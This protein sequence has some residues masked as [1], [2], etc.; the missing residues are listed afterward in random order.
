ML[1]PRP[2]YPGPRP[3]YIDTMV[4]RLK[5]GL[6]NHLRDNL[7]P[8]NTKALIPIVSVVDSLPETL[9]DYKP[10]DILIHRGDGSIYRVIAGEGGIVKHLERITNPI[11]GVAWGDIVDKPTEFPPSEHG[12]RAA[13]IGGLGGPDVI[14]KV[15]DY[16]YHAV[17]SEFNRDAAA[18][19]ADSIRTMSGACS[20][21]RDGKLVGRNFDWGFD[22]SPSFVVQ[23]PAVGGRRASVSMCRAPKNLDVSD[24]ND[25]LL[26]VVPFLALDGVNDAGVFCEVNVV[27]LS[28]R[29]SG[30]SGNRLCAV[31]AVREALDRF[32]DAA[33]AAAMIA[34][35]CWIPNIG[36][37]LHFMVCDPKE[38]WIVEDGVATKV[39]GKAV[40]TNFR[41]N[42]GEFLT[43]G[44]PDIEKV[45][46]FDPLGTGLERYG[47]LLNGDT[48]DLA[49]LDSLMLDA[50]FTAAYDRDAQPRRYTEF[51]GCYLESLGREVTLA[52]GLAF[53]A[54]YADIAATSWESGT[55]ESHRGETGP[56]G[57]P[58]W[59]QSVHSSIYDLEARTLSVAIQELAGRR[60]FGIVAE[61]P[62]RSVDGK[63]PDASGNVRVD[64]K[65]FA[66]KTIALDTDNDLYE[67]VQ[68][69]IESLGGTVR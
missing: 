5:D 63:R 26:A 19:Y 14:E 67:A 20:V 37:D 29:T 40:M 41:V 52:D 16:L 32:T 42:A 4:R 43:D 61:S 47:L 51:A 10:T 57:S 13:D 2:L 56:D 3:P 38:T 36:Y 25:P 6:E 33:S 30:W 50:R 64:V 66:G 59:W 8:H 11:S 1:K 27:P 54:E 65:P 39:T 60:S 23:A 34:S 55:K 31:F 12:H 17:W 9:D 24:P 49:H 22:S 53:L 45:A 48:S 35:D 69:V 62:V 21:V 28:N 46:A 18:K 15:C 44:S 58:K 68:K 7:D